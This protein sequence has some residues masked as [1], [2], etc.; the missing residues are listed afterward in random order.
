VNGSGSWTPA[1]DLDSTTILVP[2][3]FGELVFTVT[4]ANGNVIEQDTTPP[5]TKG[6]GTSNGTRATKTSCMF[7]GSQTDPAGNTF[8]ITGSVTGFVTPARG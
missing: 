4:D 3:A 5:S 2:L 6:A 1:H 7:S 8:T